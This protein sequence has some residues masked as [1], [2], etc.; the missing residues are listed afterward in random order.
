MAGDFWFTDAFGVQPIT[1]EQTA[2]IGK[3]AP[4]LIDLGLD[5][6]ITVPA[7]T[8]MTF[9]VKVV[10][11][12]QTGTPIIDVPVYFHLVPPSGSTIDIFAGNTGLDGLVYSPSHL[13][14][15]LGL[16]SFTASIESTD[17]V[18]AGS[19]APLSRSFTV[20]QTQGFGDGGNGDKA[21]AVA[22]APA[23]SAGHGLSTAAIVSLAVVPSVLAVLLA[24]YVWRRCVASRHEK[25]GRKPAITAAAH[26]TT[27]S[28]PTENPNPMV[29]VTTPV[30]VSDVNVTVESA[31]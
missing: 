15:A 5:P 21:S 6:S 2:N 9:N 26:T 30:A 28:K 1:I 13:V 4:A 19:S 25:A 27:R 11:A 18:L 14:T 8:G 12:T 22:S 16:Y 23:D 24:V 17:C 31:L 3:S 20:H 29:A 7:G 10:Y